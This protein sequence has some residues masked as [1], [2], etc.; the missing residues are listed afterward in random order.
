MTR[1]IKWAIWLYV[2]LLIFEGAL[3]K[4]FLPG[5][6]NPLLLV[7]DPVVLFIYLMAVMGGVVPRSRF[8]TVTGALLLASV[9]FSFLAGQTNLWV[10]LYGIHT[11][12]LH[13]PL[14]WIVAELLDRED[15]ERLS[16]FMLLTTVVVSAVMVLQFE[17]PANAWINRGVG[18]DEGGQLY[19][20]AGRN[21]SPSVF[22][23]ITGPMSFFPL[24]AAFFFGALIKPHKG[25]WRLLLTTLT[26]LSIAVALPVSISRG[27]VIATL[28]VAAVFVIALFISGA[29]KGIWIRM[30]IV[31]VALIAAL[32]FLPIF[33]TG[34]DAFMSRWDL[35]AEEVGGDE[36]ADLTGRVTSIFYVPFRDLANAPFFGHGIGVGSSVGS[37]LLVGKRGFLLAEDEWDCIIL[38]L[39]P[40]LGLAFIALRIVLVVHLGLVAAKAL[41]NR[42]D[43][44]PTLIY[45]A[46]AYLVLLGQW[47]QPTQ[48]GFAVVGAGFLLA[49]A[50][51]EE[52]SEDT[53]NEETEEPEEAE[54]HEPSPENE[55]EARR[56]RMRGL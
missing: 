7:R 25:P 48:L 1:Y 29:I 41:K 23:F 40:L 4:W 26:G 46:C 42:K 10:I 54:P 47:R 44:M 11:N 3:R 34:S 37:Q 36:V 55:L 50:K 9:V 30:T 39:G 45:A 14:I 5:L 56:R 27:T 19:G 18:G 6:A 16:L 22:S 53:E 21:R 49:A 17:S 28:F 12:Y 13:L 24:A 35:A 43:M 32:S 31:S 51:R 2:F 38:E 52:S 8:I 33:Q 15:L 20:A